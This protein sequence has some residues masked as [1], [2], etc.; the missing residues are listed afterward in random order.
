ME[1]VVFEMK[2]TCFF[3]FRLVFR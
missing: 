3:F 2:E 1:H